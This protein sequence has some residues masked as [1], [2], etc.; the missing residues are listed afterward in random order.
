M[1]RD[2]FLIDVYVVAMVNFN[3]DGFKTRL[4]QGNIAV[5][6]SATLF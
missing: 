3:F 2:N 4:E 6:V 1:C 5:A